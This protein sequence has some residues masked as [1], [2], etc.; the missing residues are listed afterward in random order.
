MTDAE[1]LLWSKVRLKQL[2]GMQFYRQKIIGNYIADFLCYQSKLVIEVDGSQHYTDEGRKT[3]LKRDAYFNQ[4]GYKVL[5]FTDI[6]VLQNINGVIE[7]I[8][9]TINS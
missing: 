5:R 8:L 7:K 6:D 1:R 2:N 9:E 4:R 3:D